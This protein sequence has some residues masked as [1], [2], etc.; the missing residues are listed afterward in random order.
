MDLLPRISSLYSQTWVFWVMFTLLAVAM[1]SLIPQA[2]ASTLQAVFSRAERTYSVRNREWMSELTLRLFRVGV[3]AMALLIWIQPQG[4]ASLLNYAKALGIL[5][6]VYAVQTLLIYAV[7]AVFISSKRMDV[8]MEQ[9]SAIRTLLCVGLYPILLL[10]TNLSLPSLPVIA[11][12]IIFGLYIVALIAKGIQLF[13]AHILS[14]L[15]IL[16]YIVCLE[17]LPLLVSVAVA[18]RII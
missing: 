6:A 14:I 17:V 7:G 10:L 12:G 1:L 18:E 2:A 15:Y 4:E 13:Y 16:L 11:Y 9:Y 3:L 8:A 5:V